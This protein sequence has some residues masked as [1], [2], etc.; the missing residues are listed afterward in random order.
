MAG[1]RTTVRWSESWLQSVSIGLWKVNRF[2][3]VR[4]LAEP[5][6]FGPPWCPCWPA[7]PR[8]KRPGGYF[9]HF[10]IAGDPGGPEGKGRPAKERGHHHPMGFLHGRWKAQRT[11]YWRFRK[12]W[13]SACIVAGLPERIFHDF[14]RTAV[15]N[16]VWAGVPECAAMK[17]TGHKTRSVFERN[18]T[19]SKGDLRD[20]A[21]WLDRF[22]AKDTAKDGLYGG[23]AKPVSD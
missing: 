1:A 2:N 14:R 11:P 17:M 6:I 18:K 21:E 5:R 22:S 9:L 13:E 4:F 8:T 16:L 15:R 20:A 19:I 10:R 3:A 7:R 23:R 12:K